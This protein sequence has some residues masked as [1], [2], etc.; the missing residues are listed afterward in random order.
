MS[1]IVCCV[2]VRQ[3][4]S[5]FN[6]SRCDEGG[7]LLENMIMKPVLGKL[8]II[9]TF[10]MPCFIILEVLPTEKAIISIVLAIIGSSIY[11]WGFKGGVISAVYSSLMTLGFLS[12][13]PWA[14]TSYSPFMVITLYLFAGI[15]GGKIAS[16]F[17][18][19]FHSASRTSTCCSDKPLIKNPAYVKGRVKQISDLIKEVRQ[20]KIDLDIARQNFEYAEEEIIDVAVLKLNDAVERYD[21]LM[22]ILEKS[23]DR[24]G[25]TVKINTFSRG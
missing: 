24:H 9:I 21:R 7:F 11:Y 12:F 19:Y 8:L 22:E 3:I 10:F 16:G 6:V 25:L 23:W 18:N 17:H 5:M 13:A 15:G 20:A 1:N 2:A 14:A 4:G